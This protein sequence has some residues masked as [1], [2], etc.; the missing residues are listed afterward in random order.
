MR[1]IADMRPRLRQVLLGQD[2][3]V[4]AEHRHLDHHEGFSS[5]DEQPGSHDHHRHSTNERTPLV[6]QG[7]SRSQN[8][9]SN[10]LAPLRSK[11]QGAAQERI[12]QLAQQ[13]E[14]TRAQMKDDEREPLLI[15]KVQRDDGTEAEVIVG[16]STLPQT[17]FNS[18]NVLIGVGI[19]SL[20]L[21]IK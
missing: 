12:E 3:E 1:S 7:N 5:D 10:G 21:G 16:Q 14:E 6:S 8:D 17:I 11:V 2:E 15:T 19:L 9:T 13:R 18:S 4:T 20:P